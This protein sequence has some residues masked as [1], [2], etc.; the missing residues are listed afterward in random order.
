MKSKRCD[1]E[2]SE[3][4]RLEIAGKAFRPKLLHCSNCNVKMKK[5][6]LEIRLG[7]N[8][9]MRL[10]GFECQKCGKQYLGLEEA[11]KLDRAMILARA[12]NRGFKM[13]RNLSFDGDNYTFRIPKEFTQKVTKKKIE[14]VPLG[15]REFCAAVE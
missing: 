7:Q 8:I 14:I 2:K 3:E 4:A 6:A 5:R 12:I 13:V 1:L 9:S 10:E 15:A 11:R